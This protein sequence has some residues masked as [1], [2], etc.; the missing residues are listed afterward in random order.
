MT[1]KPT[2]LRGGAEQPFCQE[3]GCS[4]LPICS[5]SKRR[6]CQQKKS[7]RKPSGDKKEVHGCVQVEKCRGEAREATDTQR[8]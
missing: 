1:C 5:N 7:F 8:P 3:L 6:D 2:Q 4:R